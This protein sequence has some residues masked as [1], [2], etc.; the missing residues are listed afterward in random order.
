MRPLRFG[1]V[2]LGT[3]GVGALLPAFSQ[4]TSTRLVAVCDHNPQALTRLAATPIQCY[5]ALEEMLACEEL[6]ALY[7]ATLASTHLELALK[8]FEAG[9]HVVCEKPMAANAEEARQ[10]IVAA[11]AADRRLIIMF[12]NRVK[13]EYQQIRNWILQG[14]IGR[15][16]AI[17]LQAFGKHPIAQPRR[18]RLLNEAGCLDCGIH[19]LDQARF[20]TNGGEWER[21][22]ALGAWFGEDVECAPHIGILAKLEGGPMVTFENSF[23]YG[24]NLPQVSYKFSRNH[25]TIVGSDGVIIDTMAGSTPGFQMVSRQRTDLHIIEPMAHSHE[26]AR[27][28]DEFHRTL[29]GTNPQASVLATGEDGR[30]AQVIVDEV[31]S[32]CRAARYSSP[33]LE[34]AVAMS[35]PTSHSVRSGHTLLELIVTIAIGLVISALGLMLMRSLS[36]GQKEAQC[37]HNLRQLAVAMHHYMNDCNQ[38]LTSFHGG[39]VADNIWVRRLFLGG[40]LNSDTSGAN[41]NAILLK[42]IDSVGNL[43]R[44]PSANVETTYQNQDPAVRAH[45]R[46][47]GWQ[48]YGLGM[49]DTSVPLV[50]V[51]DAKGATNSFAVRLSSIAR[52]ANYLL[53]SDSSVAGPHFYQSFRISRNAGE[54]GVGLRHQK[55]A[56]AIFLDGHMEKVTHQR[57]LDLGVPAYNIYE[58][59]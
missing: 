9:L 30:L 7:I 13:A 47:W 10:M 55:R 4:S 58:V 14:E 39:A 26:I 1:L 34:E 50:R 12:E 19:M 35:H 38:T 11:E 37:A 56:N 25:L 28:L 6:D 59:P 24:L 3:H 8:G 5:T 16:E 18:T 51:V 43:M 41:E 52:P 29:S 33:L 23:S 20:W 54:G 21:I 22:H 27:A 32:Q 17:H 15:V 2:G 53:F 44:C 40:Y 42:Q 48:A 31:N 49:F 46:R 36:G 57:A 45:P